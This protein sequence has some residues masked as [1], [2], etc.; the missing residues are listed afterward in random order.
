MTEDQALAA[1]SSNLLRTSEV[2]A[3]QGEKAQ[4]IAT[5][6][7]SQSQ[8]LRENVLNAQALKVLS[9][10]DEKV[11]AAEPLLTAALLIQNCRHYWYKKN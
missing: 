10:I 8:K 7:L 4:P 3:I 2:V 1:I 9:V 6:F 11:L 5:M